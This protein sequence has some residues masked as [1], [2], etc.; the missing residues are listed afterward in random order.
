MR[1]RKEEDIFDEMCSCI[2][3]K[4]K[5]INSK[6]N[7]LK[8]SSNY[9][10]RATGARDNT[11]GDCRHHCGINIQSKSGKMYKRCLTP[12]KF[13]KRWCKEMFAVVK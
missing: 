8:D 6:F 3:E 2:L 7:N 5:I 11:F 1:K 12:L 9:I 13:Y 10:I 4:R